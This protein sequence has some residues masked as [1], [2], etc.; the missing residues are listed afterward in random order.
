MKTYNLPLQKYSIMNWRTILGLILL[1][2]GMWELYSVMANSAA[3][4]LSM[5]PAYI[6]FACIV[7]MAV[8]V[9]LIVKGTRGKDQQ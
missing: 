2:V 6:E 1:I 7:W 5:S 8:G 9:F 3:V 4:K